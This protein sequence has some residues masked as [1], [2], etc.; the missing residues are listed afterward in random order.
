M[1]LS[2]HSSTY[3]FLQQD[4]RFQAMMQVSIVN[5]GPVTLILDSKESR[6]GTTKS[7]EDAEK[8]QEIADQ[9]ARRRQEVETRTRENTKKKQAASNDSKVS[10]D[11]L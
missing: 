6:D 7:S 3:N 10:E 4:G 11:A 1:S 8:S 2:S 9:K 5:E